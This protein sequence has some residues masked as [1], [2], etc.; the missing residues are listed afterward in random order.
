MF[1]LAQHHTTCYPRG[2]VAVGFQTTATLLL[3]SVYNWNESPSSINLVFLIRNANNP[4]SITRF[5]FSVFSDLQLQ[6]HLSINI[7]LADNNTKWL[8]PESSTTLA[9]RSSS[10]PPSSSSSPRFRHQWSTTSQSSRL[11]LPTP[12]PSV[13]PRSPLEP[14][15]TVCV[16]CPMELE[17][18]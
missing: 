4:A 12:R 13:T 3:P 15:D 1:V 5:D 17:S 16:M 6:P 18:K 14:L 8:S 9:R 2:V 10:F 11:L 7:G